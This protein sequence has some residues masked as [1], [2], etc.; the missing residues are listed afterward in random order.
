MPI[1]CWPVGRVEVGW[2]SRVGVGH[3]LRFQTGRSKQPIGRF[4]V[5]PGR[6][7]HAR[8]LALVWKPPAEAGGK[9]YA[10]TRGIIIVSA[11]AAARTA[12][13][14]AM[15]FAHEASGLMN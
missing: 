15:G 3:E 5:P 8:G 10:T 13:V 4:R 14:M 9:G 6:V 7:I 11:G 2:C 12:R 1:G